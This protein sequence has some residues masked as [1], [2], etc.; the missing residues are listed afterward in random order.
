[1]SMCVLKYFI[2][3]VEDQEIEQILEFALNLSEK[4]VQTV[5]DLFTY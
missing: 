4:H 2:K 1:M 3:H 5:Q